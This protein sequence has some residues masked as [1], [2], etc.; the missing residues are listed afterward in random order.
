MPR[1]IAAMPKDFARGFTIAPHRH[2]RAQ[3]IYAPTGAMRVSAAGSLWMVP[4]QRALWMP[5]GVEHSIRML[6]DV[7]MRTLYLREDVASVMPRTCHVLPVSRLLRELI[8]RATELPVDYDEAGPAGHLVAL[9]L[10]ELHGLRALPLDLP[11]PGDARVMAVCR[12]ILD[13]PGDRRGLADWARD[14][15]VSER[16]LARLFRSETGLSFGAWRQQ[17]RLLEAMGRLGAG[18]PVTRVALDLGYDSIS[19]F[20][21]MFRRATA[22]SPRT[23]RGGG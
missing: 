17:A 9:L 14:A 2:L 4:P 20:S 16:T 5:P 7:T 1:A 3:L 19:A 11:L 22:T 8:V 13:E 10:S 23:F 6:S 18:E 21:A 15:H 12:A